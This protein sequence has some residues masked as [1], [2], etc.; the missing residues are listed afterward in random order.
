MTGPKLRPVYERPGTVPRREIPASPLAP[1]RRRRPVLLE[2]TGGGE[3]A[4]EPIRNQVGRPR[5]NKARP[6]AGRRLLVVAGAPPSPPGPPMARALR[7][8]SSC[9]TATRPR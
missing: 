6:Q 2:A 9:F 7:G 5:T 8:Q 4:A 1:R 3:P